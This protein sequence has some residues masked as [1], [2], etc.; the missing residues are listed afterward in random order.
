MRTLPVLLLSL[1]LSSP[2]LGQ[3]GEPFPHDCTLMFEDI[4][5]DHH[6][7]QTCGPEGT[8]AS[9]ANAL[10][11]RA[12]NNFCIKGTPSRITRTTFVK[13]QSA[14][15]DAGVRSGSP[16]DD[17]SVLR[18]L[19]T[20]SEGETIGE[21]S[22]VELVGFIIDA[23]YSNVSNGESVNCKKRGRESNDIHIVLDESKSVTDFCHT[24]TAEMSPHFRPEDWDSGVLQELGRPVRL[25]GQLFFDGSHG[26][27]RP[28]HPAS[29]KRAS[30]WEIHPVYRVD[31][32][33]NTSIAGCSAHDESKW[34]PLDEFVTQDEKQHEIAEA[35][36]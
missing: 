5:M 24:V 14:A 7:D 20:T 33:R 31:V 30:V 6:L 17:R 29:P 32:C 21:G 26:P 11:N 19:H 35:D 36:E 3:E 34:I 4:S 18:D 16:P 28:G 1:L 2:L 10:Q 15:D 22:L 23:H 12:K 13:L 8:P 25:T 9:P 27:C